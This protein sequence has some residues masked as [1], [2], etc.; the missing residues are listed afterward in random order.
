M[1]AFGV[2][3]FAGR[4]WNCWCENYFF[5]PPKL[6]DPVPL[7]ISSS[8]KYT[9]YF[10]NCIAAVDGTHIPAV[11]PVDKQIPF[12]NRIKLLSQ[13]VLAVAKHLQGG[14]RS[15][16]DSRVF[17]GAK[18]AGLPMFPG[19][20]YLGYAGYA[21]SWQVLTPYRGVR[22]HL[23]EYGPLNQRP[24][25]AKKLYD[26]HHLGLRNKIERI[27]GVAKKRFRFLSWWNLMTFRFNA[28][29]LF[30]HWCCITLF[31]QISCTVIKVTYQRKLE[32]A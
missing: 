3:N 9:P 2:N 6:N 30:V 15:A 23:K 31:A 13:N 17:R 1:A 26:Y 20:Y 16:H 24:Q 32:L 11:I 25:N 12:R 22:Y 18:V 21:W 28:T 19:K 14:E 27:F 10:D 4:S 7:R 5:F 8:R 29:L